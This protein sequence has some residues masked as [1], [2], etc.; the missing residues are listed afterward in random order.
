M[1][2]QTPQPTPQRSLL[3]PLSPI[4]R[5]II[6]SVNEFMAH[7][8]WWIIMSVTVI[9]IVACNLQ[10]IHPLPI[11]ITTVWMIWFMIMAKRRYTLRIFVALVILWHL[12]PY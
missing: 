5:W 3:E 8:T 2:H 12:Y 1:L 4:A 10:P 6:N 11:F 7:Q 9:F